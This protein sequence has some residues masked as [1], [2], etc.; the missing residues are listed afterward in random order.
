MEKKE[1]VYI[2]V[3]KE[4]ENVVL[5]K[6]YVFL[7]YSYYTGDFNPEI[8][9]NAYDLARL[10]ELIEAPNFESSGLRMQVKLHLEGGEEKMGEI[11]LPQD[12]ARMSP[13]Q[14]RELGDRLL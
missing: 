7:N 12:V 4:T 1:K 9:I 3:E 6:G 14:L 13:S 8:K 10:L 11:T 2:E 5:N